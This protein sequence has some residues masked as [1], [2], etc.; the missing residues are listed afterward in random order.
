M[1]SN[2]RKS[3]HSNPVYSSKTKKLRRKITHLR[4]GGAVDEKL[5]FIKIVNVLGFTSQEEIVNI[6]SR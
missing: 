5:L 3:L 6:P 4:M 2:N 1:S